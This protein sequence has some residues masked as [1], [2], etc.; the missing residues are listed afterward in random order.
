M[1]ASHL[2]SS[3]IF[4]SSPTVQV[5]NLLDLAVDLTKQILDADKCSLMLLVKEAGE[6]VVKKARGLDEEVMKQARV[7]LG[8]G[9]AG[10][11]AVNKKPVLVEGAHAFPDLERRFSDRYATQSFISVPILADGSV[12]VLN[13][14]DKRDR[15][16]FSKLDL[17][18]L[19]RMASLVGELLSLHETVE[20]LQETN[21]IDTLTGLRNWRYFQLRLSQ[22]L[23]R[24]RRFGQDL[25]LLIMDIDH[26][27]E[28][29][30]LCGHDVG[31]QVLQTIGHYLELEIR[32]SDIAARY[33][34]DEFVI[35][36][37]QSGAE[38]AEAV[39][40]RLVRSVGRLSPPDLPNGL[41][42]LSLSIG[43]SAYPTLALDEE[44]LINQADAA[45]RA[46][47][48]SL[49]QR[50]QTWRS[51][52]ER[53]A[54]AQRLGIPYLASPV[55]MLT[56]DIARLIPFEIARRHY[57]VPI[58]FE[59]GNLTLALLDP[60]DSELLKTLSTVTRLTIHPVLSNSAEIMTALSRLAELWG[61]TAGA[62]IIVR[63]MP[64]G[65]RELKISVSPVVTGA[66]L[67]QTMVKLAEA[68]RSLGISIKT[69]ESYVMIV[70]TDSTGSSRLLKALRN[71][72]GLLIES[73]R[74]ENHQR[75]HALSSAKRG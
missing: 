6:L 31:N 37:P 63:K 75:S 39:A 70:T 21:L 19:Q 7:R 54:E 18:L 38:V 59:R 62:D 50:I 28:L 22:E 10:R 40:E 49:A 26:F 29:N 57:C 15:G 16:A 11:V 30:D 41:A 33:G 58:G 43:I 68:C 51:A 67:G 34:G 5:E 32:R 24:A 12:G 17:L 3:L 74:T 9:V 23:A 8:D 25:A 20:F 65:G 71:L 35:I 27:K 2:S 66:D 44:Q 61:K 52:S 69:A 73:V 72:D 64:K 47:K 60:T 13:A 55:D 56:A 1:V 53:L 14:A 48:R 4:G 46:A 45:L 42:A 36:L